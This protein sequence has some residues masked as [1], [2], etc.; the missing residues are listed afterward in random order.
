[1]GDDGY[2][3]VDFSLCRTCIRCN[4]PE[5]DDTCSECLNCPSRY[6]SHKPLKYEEDPKKVQNNG[7][8]GEQI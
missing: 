8:N 6:A 5:D 1:M 3:I 4:E 7:N 2:K